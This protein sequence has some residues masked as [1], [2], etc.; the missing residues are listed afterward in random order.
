MEEM[1]LLQ[2]EILELLENRKFA[3][4]GKILK[5][6]EPADVAYIMDELPEED[7]PVVF[8]ILPKELAADTFAELDG[9][10][11][12]LL[13][14]SFSDKELRAVMD[15]MFVDDA[16]D[17]IEEMPAN[18]VARILK[19]TDPETRKVINTILQYPEDSAGSIMTVEYV[20]LRKD[21]T[22][23]DAFKRIRQVGI[24]KETIYNCYVTEN[25]KLI[26]IVTVKDMLLAAEECLVEEIMDDHV[27][28]VDAYEDKELVAEQF[29]KYGLMAMPVVDKEQRLVG[30]VTFDDAM[31]VLQ[32]ENTED[33]EMM[34]AV[35]P[36]DKPYLKTGVFETWKKRILWLAL[37]LLS[38]TFT[39]SILRFF[40]ESLAAQSALIMFIPMIMGTGGNAG[41]QSSVTIIRGLSLNEITMKDIWRIMWKEFRVSIL[42][43][44]TLSIVTFAK[45]L[46]FDRLSL[47]VAAVVSLTIF[48]TLILAKLV[49]CI[50]PMLAKK[51]GFDPAVMASPFI[52]TIVDALSMLIYFEIAKWI[53]QM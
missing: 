37:L 49:G 8:R 12:E 53:L 22:V 26:G 17:M 46:L 6:M 29:R 35:T 10:V 42:C 33:I 20:F 44:V 27:I 28:F 11:Q 41:G 38:A 1:E 50:L 31:D 47:L 48:A 16:V 39:S 40:E 14:T 13:V 24:D 25:R 9:D 4:L 3:A 23:S 34:A 7:L 36:T 5:E 2:E 21:I 45:V 52:T 30:I 18:V 15:E 43:G 19:N 51:I 32:E